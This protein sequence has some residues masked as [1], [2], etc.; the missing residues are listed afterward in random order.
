ME[1][2]YGKEDI[3][4]LRWSDGRKHRSPTVDT[5]FY[6]HEVRNLVK[7]Q[8]II[9]TAISLLL[10]NAYGIIIAGTGLSF[11]FFYDTQSA[12]NQNNTNSGFLSGS[13]IINC[14][15]YDFYPC[16]L[17]YVFQAMVALGAAIMVLCSLVKS[18]CGV[19]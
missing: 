2:S 17:V 19:W 6:P 3:N 8:N 11:Y 4:L 5:Y 9:E 12:Y 13:C 14:G 18:C 1:D 10:I 7:R 15:N 16:I